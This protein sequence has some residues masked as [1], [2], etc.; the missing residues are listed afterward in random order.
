MRQNVIETIIGFIILAV[1]GWFFVYAYSTNSMK[2]D[3]DGYILAA[4]FQNAEGIVVG[5]DIMTAGIKIGEVS[6]MTLDRNTFFAVMKL[7]INKGIQIPEDSQASVVSSGFLGGKFIS[8]TPGAS[9]TDLKNNDAIKFTQ[10]SVNIE[11]LIGKFMYSFGSNSNSSSG[12]STEK[13]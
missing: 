7:R 9:D 10:S 4:K 12:S 3:S 5:S 1:T 2:T 11:S 13:K 8:I 6:E